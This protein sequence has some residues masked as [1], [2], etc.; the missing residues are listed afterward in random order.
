MIFA[1]RDI[2]PIGYATFAFAL[3]VAA[4]VLVR[5][6]LPAMAL[7]LVAV[8]AIQILMP[9][10]VRPQ[11]IPP[12]HTIIAFDPQNI[13][14][15]VIRGDTYMTVS[16]PV[17]IPGAW[18]IANQT[19]TPTGQPF[20]GPPPPACLTPTDSEQPC[21]AALDQLHLR[22]RVTYQPADR[23]WTFQWLEAAILLVLSGALTVACS[24]RIRRLRLP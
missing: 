10:V 21:Y 1:G 19:I 14:R 8:A 22:Q 9:V 23:Y 12:A 24:W 4:G 16:G 11:L 3:G 18:I 5:R 17:N 20:I 2:A 15:I 7:T 6:T 13:E